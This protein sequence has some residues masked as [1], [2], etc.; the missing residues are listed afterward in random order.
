MAKEKKQSKPT[1]MDKLTANYD[2][3]VKGK[4]TAEN[5]KELF[6]KAIKKATKPLG[7]K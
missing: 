6:D 4:E 1:Q 5:G 2:E 7:S 3:I